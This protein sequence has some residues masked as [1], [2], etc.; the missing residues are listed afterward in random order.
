[1]TFLNIFLTL[2]LDVRPYN[3]TSSF[4]IH[5]HVLKNFHFWVLLKS[6]FWKSGFS[7]TDTKTCFNLDGWKTPGLKIGQALSILSNRSAFE[8]RKFAQRQNMSV[9]SLRCWR[10]IKTFCHQYP[11]HKQKDSATDSN[12]RS[13]NQSHF[14]WLKL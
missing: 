2:I 8:T 14:R 1:M 11:C 13:G 12:T 9:P 7:D 5:S 3:M 10:H 4:P 6:S